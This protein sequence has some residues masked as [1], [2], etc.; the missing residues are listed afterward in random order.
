MKVLGLLAERLPEGRN[1]C[2]RVA[3]PASQKPQMVPGVR[4]GIGVGG[5]KLGARSKLSAGFS[6]LLQLQA[7]LL[8]P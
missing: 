4:H 1:S 7:W 8:E 2:G 3:L 6:S 5:V